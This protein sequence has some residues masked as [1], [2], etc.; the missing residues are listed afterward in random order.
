M[1]GP[2]GKKTEPKIET[3]I[4]VVLKSMNEY[5]PESEEYPKLLSFLERLTEVKTKNR[6]P[7]VSHDTMFTV[8]GNLLGILIIVAYEQNHV[9]VS[10][11]LGFVNKTK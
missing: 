4:E 9:M 10:K 5:G 3:P 7:R 11:A 6:P 2:K 1:F 8:A